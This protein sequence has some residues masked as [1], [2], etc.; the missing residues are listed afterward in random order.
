[1]ANCA[2]VQSIQTCGTNFS[3]YT[4]QAFSVANSL[5]IFAKGCFPD[6]LCLLNQGCAILNETR[7]GTI[8]SCSFNCCYTDWCNRE[9]DV[10]STTSPPAPSLT[11]PV[12]TTG[13]QPS[14][15]PSNRPS[16]SPE[17]SPTKAAMPLTATPVP[18]T[19]LRKNLY[20]FFFFHCFFEFLFKVK[21]T[22][23]AIIGSE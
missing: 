19:P 7:N 12:A 4:L 10:P 2:L 5:T 15:I 23:F 9:P 20:V 8:G 13:S 14:M 18:T 21:F 6:F 3:C 11:G 1:M 16:A 22:H 17:T